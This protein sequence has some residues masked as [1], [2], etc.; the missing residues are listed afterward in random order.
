M[1]QLPTDIHQLF[2]YLGTPAFI[3]F[4]LSWLAANWQWFNS[5]KLSSQGRTLVMFLLALGLGIVSKLLVQ[6]VPEGA[7]SVLQP[8]YDVFLSTVMII[9]GSQLW[10]SHVVSRKARTIALPTAN[11]TVTS[12][13]GETITKSTAIDTSKG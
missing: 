4:V 10:Y 1:P 3:G 9:F 8:Y 7:Y 11:L 13:T 12:S 5:N 6:Y 2:I